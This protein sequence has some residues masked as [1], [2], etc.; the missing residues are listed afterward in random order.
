[1]STAKPTEIHDFP[2]EL[3]SY[4]GQFLPPADL[5]HATATCREWFLWLNPLSTT[6][7]DDRKIIEAARLGNFGYAIKKI[8]DR[9]GYY[10]TD[11]IGEVMVS[12]ARLHD[13]DLLVRVIGKLQDESIWHRTAAHLIARE[14]WRFIAV[15]IG[16]QQ[17]LAPYW[18]FIYHAI[19][20]NKHDFL[21][22]LS[23][24]ITK[25]HP[26][27]NE[28]FSG[29][30]D[31]KQM[32]FIMCSNDKNTCRYLKIYTAVLIA[33]RYNDSNIADLLKTTAA[34]VTGV[35]SMGLNYD[36]VIEFYE[37]ILQSPFA[38]QFFRIL[39]SH[40]MYL[41]A[42]AADLIPIICR[43][44]CADVLE[45]LR[46]QSLI[47][48]ECE[49]SLSKWLSSTT[50]FAR[51]HQFLVAHRIKFDHVHFI[52]TSLIQYDQ[53][54]EDQRKQRARKICTIIDLAPN[55]DAQR[56]YLEHAALYPDAMSRIWA[57]YSKYNLTRPTIATDLWN[58]IIER[59]LVEHC[60]LALKLSIPR[61]ADL[62]DSAVHAYIMT[63]HPFRH[64]ILRLLDSQ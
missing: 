11:V 2:P 30:F 16:R 28:I 50:T 54:D 62:H 42:R 43:T 45:F 26:I 36:S 41:H 6:N 3:L 23:P 63:P 55:R 40:P 7:T 57:H 17:P 8:N 29:N 31:Q 21:A 35:S 46:D 10:K 38:L 52:Q 32:R 53:L 64:Q 22:K 59:A 51:D 15:V 47:T 14:E 18:I 48:S 33:R 39:T 1:M 5:V 4:M 9:N 44:R 60:H 49:V 19:L 20:L 58:L 56:R 37:T 25:E 27:K 61:P 13:M 12:A 34:L 24:I